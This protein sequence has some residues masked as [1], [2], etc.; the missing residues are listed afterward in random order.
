MAGSID[1]ESNRGK[2][3]L[4]IPAY[5]EAGN[6]SKVVSDILAQEFPMDYVIVSDGS[7][8][9]TIELCE[10]EG[11]NYISLPVNLGLA[12]C[13][14]TGMKYAYRMG[15]SYA[16]QFDGD[17]Q[18]RASDIEALYDK[19][20]EG[21]YDIVLGSRF[22]N[23][24][25]GGSMREIGSRLISMAIRLT[26]GKVITDPTCGL[27]MYSER[28]IDG[29]ANKLNY[30]P[31]PDTIS[32]LMKNGANVTEAPVTIDERLSGESYLRPVNAMKYMARMLISIL[33][34][35]SSR[36]KDL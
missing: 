15:Y 36:K 16:V 12:G 23:R 18:H 13:F 1:R 34:V 14:Q 24:N 17:G 11:Y 30:G 22:L 3:I 8:D 4:I 21:N 20:R 9:G 2:V 32:Y 5:N 28:V 29:F 31:E 26:T 10:R 35:Q 6:L 19:M 25:K 7:T 27:R 33:V